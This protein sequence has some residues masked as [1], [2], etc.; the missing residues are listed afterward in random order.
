M[1]SKQIEKS[2]K[3]YSKYYRNVLVN[4]GVNDIQ[5]RIDSY[6]K[7]LKK[8]Y[9][10]DSFGAH[11]IFT[12][13]HAY[14]LEVLA[15]TNN[16]LLSDVLPHVDSPY[17]TSSL[18]NSSFYSPIPFS[19]A[20]GDMQPI[21]PLSRYSSF[22]SIPHSIFRTHGLSQNAIDYLYFLDQHVASH[23]KSFLS[24]KTRPDNLG[25]WITSIRKRI[26]NYLSS[27]FC[28]TSFSVLI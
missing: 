19:P 24:N 14:T 16:S 6:K 18:H 11:D 5:G 23:G 28:N 7:R 9:E 4:E 10:S 27:T 21:H 25:L 15:P 3:S 1:N 20:L 2:T 17:P 22:S 26:T 8:M 13:S 12:Q